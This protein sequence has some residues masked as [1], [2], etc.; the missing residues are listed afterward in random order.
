[1]TALMN[2]DHQ[3]ALEVVSSQLFQLRFDDGS[4]HTP[5]FFAVHGDGSRV[6]YDLKASDRIRVPSPRSSTSPAPRATASVGA[7]KC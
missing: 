7:T 1:M 6:V 2:L 4:K 3:Y 5:D